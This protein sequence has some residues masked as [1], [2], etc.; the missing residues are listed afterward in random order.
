MFTMDGKTIKKWL[1]GKAFI[2]LILVL[3][4][5]TTVNLNLNRPIALPVHAPLLVGP[6]ANYSD[7]PLANKQVESMLVGILNNKGFNRVQAF[8]AKQDCNKL[9]YCPEEGISRDHLLR[10]ARRNHYRYILTGAVNE[11]RY[12]VGLDGEPVAGVSLMILDSQT[13]QTLWSGV[14]SIIGSPRLGLDVVGQD[15]LNRILKTIRPLC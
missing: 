10:W 13:G 3:T 5:C 4:A 1:I 7:T 15:L 12:K 2:G 11:W 14:G 8:P 9:L 6:I